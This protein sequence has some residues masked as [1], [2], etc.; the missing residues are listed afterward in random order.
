MILIL[1]FDNFEIYMRECG[2]VVCLTHVIEV[3]GVNLLENATGK[4]KYHGIATVV[5]LVAGDD[6]WRI[7]HWTV[8]WI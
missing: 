5:F 8:F 1:I 7:R 3:I 6:S 2:S 4:W